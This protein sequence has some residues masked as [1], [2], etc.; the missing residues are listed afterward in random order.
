MSIYSII[1]IAKIPP[2]PA[3][4]TANGL[5][6]LAAPVLLE[7]VGE[8]LLAPAPLVT[9]DDEGKAV[10]LVAPVVVATLDAALV[11]SDSAGAYLQ[12]NMKSG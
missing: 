2:R 11:D 10:D 8:A 4:T 7:V 9:E 6:W 12:N 5:V 1:A 3:A